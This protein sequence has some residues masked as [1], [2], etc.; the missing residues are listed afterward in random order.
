MR[1]AR[2]GRRLRPLRGSWRSKR[3]VHKSSWLD[4]VKE[5]CWSA[6]SADVG[7]KASVQ[8]HRPR[9]SATRL[10][11]LLTGGLVV[12][13]VGLGVSIYKSMGHRYPILGRLSPA[14]AWASEITRSCRGRWRSRK[15]ARRP[16]RARAAG[17]SG[18][19][20]DELPRGAV[21]AAQPLPTAAAERSAPAEG[22]PQGALKAERGW[23]FG[24]LPPLSG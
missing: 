1:I 14:Y 21:H 3:P 18:R 8:A 24:A 19:V 11:W 23:L 15:S 5:S 12:T 4:G 9:R 20:H 13:V 22:A 10:V 17:P 2:H 16:P 7:S 6:V